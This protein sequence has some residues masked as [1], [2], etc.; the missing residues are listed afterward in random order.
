MDILERNVNFA[1]MAEED[2]SKVESVK[3]KDIKYRAIEVSSFPEAVKR[4]MSSKGEQ[5]FCFVDFDHTLTGSELGN[6]R[7]PK[8][9]ADVKASFNHLLSEFS[10]GRLC[11]TTNRGYGC[12]VL[13]NLVL[14]TD[15]ALEEMVA[16]LEE[17]RYPGTV[18]IFLGLKKQVPNLKGNGRGELIDHLVNYAIR[19]DFKDKVE[20]FMIQDFSLLGLDR[21]VFPKEIAEKMQLKVKEEL[22]RDIGIDIV[23]YV[24][25]K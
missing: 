21:R 11:I 4:I 8:I 12:S 15:K 7:N 5:S 23:D 16:L 2:A 17:S 22:S 3:K 9:S 14:K 6:I 18:P 25:K 19:N 24:L 1:T 20:I 13:G 10:P